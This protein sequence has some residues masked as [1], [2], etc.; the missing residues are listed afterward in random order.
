MPPF[1][2][3]WS[4]ASFRPLKLALRDGRIDSGHGVDHADPHGSV[5]QGPNDE[6]RRDLQ[7]R[8]GRACLQ[9][10][11]TPDH[12]GTLRSVHLVLP[13]QFALLTAALVRGLSKRKSSHLRFLVP[14]PSARIERSSRPATAGAARDVGWCAHDPERNTAHALGSYCLPRRSRRWGAT[15]P[16]GRPLRSCASGTA[17]Y[18]AD[19][20]AV[21]LTKARH[22]TGAGCRCSFS[23]MPSHPSTVVRKM[24]RLSLALAECR[25]PSLAMRPPCGGE[26]LAGEE[27]GRFAARKRR[28]A[29]FETLPATFAAARNRATDVPVPLSACRIPRE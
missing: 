28:G 7:R 17:N 23:G 1:L 3:S 15:K 22:E 8:S 5:A 9:N 27:H 14:A 10:S 26:A 25:G 21:M 19:D 11:P 16:A 24:S 18:A 4:V 6:R 29:S 12:C 20:L 13:E 2:L